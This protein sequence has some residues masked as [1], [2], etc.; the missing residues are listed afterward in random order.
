MRKAIGLLAVSVCTVWAGSAFAQG[1][2]APNPNPAGSTITLNGSEWFNNAFFDNAGLLDN[3]GTLNNN[4]LLNN[5]LGGSLF[6]DGGTLNNGVGGTLNNNHSLFNKVGG[7]L[8]NSGLLNNLGSLNNDVGGL[9]NN[10]GTLNN[11]LGGTLDN[12]GTLD[13]F[14]TLDNGGTLDNSGTITSTGTLNNNAGATMTLASGVVN[15]TTITNNGTF[16]LNGGA[17]NVDTFNGNLDNTGATLGAGNLSSFTTINGDYSQDANSTLLIDILGL[18]VSGTATLNGELKFV[19]SD[20]AGVE[21]GYSFDILVANAILGEFAS[22]SNRTINEAL[23]WKLDYGLDGSSVTA[24]AVSAVPLPAAAWLF[25]SAIA[26]LAGA[27]R[28]S[29]SKGSA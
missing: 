21:L 13:N 23:V 2:I 5:N 6:N 11:N 26:G 29:R 24:T 12:N 22:V 14:G 20:Y 25:I 27:K 4:G 8:N 3:S 17:L 1:Q 18:N 28:L 7:T 9:L 19:G 15:A 10:F 16:N